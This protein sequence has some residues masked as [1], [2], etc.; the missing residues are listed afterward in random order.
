NYGNWA[1][2]PALDLARLL[3]SMKDDHGRVTIAGFYDDVAP[4]TASEKRALDEIPDVELELMKTYGVTRR[5]NPAERIELRH[6]QP[7]LNGNALDAGGGVGG[8][9]RTVIPGSASARIDVRLVPAID[10]ARQ[11]QRIVAHVTRQ[12]YFVVDKDPDAA[13]RAAH[14]LIAKVTR[15]GG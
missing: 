7:T 11:F 4:L 1:P 2:N 10:P 14:P 12:G 3:A 8:Q 15:N 9:G 6:T 13:T 5:E